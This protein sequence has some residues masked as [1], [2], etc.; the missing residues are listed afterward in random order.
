MKRLDVQLQIEEARRRF[1]RSLVGCW[2]TAQST[3][4]GMMA[5]F[6]EIHPDGTG[7]FTDTEPFGHPQS[8]TRFEWRHAEPFAFD[9]RLTEYISHESDYADELSDEERAWRT[10]RYDFLAVPTDC[11][12][13]VGLVEVTQ[14]GEKSGGFH[15]SLAPLSY[16]KP[17]G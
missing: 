14:A 16:C 2:I 13:Q 8:E 6:W 1:E 7:R 4:N 11:G 9:L 12:V 10:I 15:L 5:Q 17:V 3:F